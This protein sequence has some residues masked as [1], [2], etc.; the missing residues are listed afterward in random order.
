MVIFSWNLLVYA[1]LADFKK[2]MAQAE[3]M[4]QPARD[5][6]RR[7]R[8]LNVFVPRPMQTDVHDH[9]GRPKCFGPLEMP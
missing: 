1:I 5:T 3:K 9:F 2:Q 7:K 4:C 6:P 8:T